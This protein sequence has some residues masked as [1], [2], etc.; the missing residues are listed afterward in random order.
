MISKARSTLTFLRVL[1]LPI[2]SSPG[3]DGKS[4]QQFHAW[5]NTMVGSL[6]EPSPAEL[7]VILNALPVIWNSVATRPG[8]IKI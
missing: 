5:V 3:P 1:A 8:E 6:A 4:I 2:A 7:F